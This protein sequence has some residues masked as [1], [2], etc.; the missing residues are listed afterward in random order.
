MASWRT[1]W[2]NGV[3]PLL[4]VE[5]LKALQ[6]ALEGDDPRLLQ[7]ATIS[8]TPLACVADWPVEA[9]CA[10]GFCGWQGDGLRTVREV[11]EFFVDTCFGIDKR[12]GESAACRWFLN[13]F[14]ETP[15]PE[16]IAALLPEVEAELAR[17]A[18]SAA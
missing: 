8:P 13:W 3:A 12:L 7:G 9:A 16:M 2:R 15:R 6:Q 14:D 5:G 17:R 11:E 4:T 1:T 10:L 18:T